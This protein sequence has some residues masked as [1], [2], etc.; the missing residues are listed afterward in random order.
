[1]SKKLVPAE[2]ISMRYLSDVG[3]GV[4]RSVILRSRGP[5]THVRSV[6]VRLGM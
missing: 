4:G 6:D 2:W 1:M 3:E 5:Y